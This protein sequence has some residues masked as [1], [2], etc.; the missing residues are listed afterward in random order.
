M[1]MVILDKDYSDAYDD[2]GDD[3]DDAG[4]DSDQNSGG[5]DDGKC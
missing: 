1:I 4:D 5:F 2:T 3:Y